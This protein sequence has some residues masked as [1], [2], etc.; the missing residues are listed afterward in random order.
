MQG[1]GNVALKRQWSAATNN[2]RF[3][4]ERHA[5]AQ[6]DGSDG[7]EVLPSPAVQHRRAT[8]P[9]QSSCAIV[10]THECIYAAEGPTEMIPDAKAELLAGKRGLVVGIANEHSIAWGCAKAFRA[11][12]AELAVTYLNE[13][14]KK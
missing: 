2:L 9:A 11:L 13:K 14:A 8:L 1:K 4:T 12:G 3:E 5:C 6:I 7:N 10:N